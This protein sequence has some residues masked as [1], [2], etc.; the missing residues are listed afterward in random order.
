MI[1]TIVLNEGDNAG[2][3]RIGR[4]CTFTIISSRT[5]VAFEAYL[6]FD[7]IHETH[8]LKEKRN[9]DTFKSSMYIICS[10]EEITVLLPRGYILP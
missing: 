2:Y 8:R 3:E 10:S 1:A 5:S 7:K 6:T 4:V 9:L